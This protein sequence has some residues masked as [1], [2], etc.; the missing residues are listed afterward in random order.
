VRET[1]PLLPISHVFL[2]PP[3]LAGI[4]SLRGEI[5]P[6]IERSCAASSRRRPGRSA[7]R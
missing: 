3:W 5:E 4:F 6:A 2:T 1:L 7:F